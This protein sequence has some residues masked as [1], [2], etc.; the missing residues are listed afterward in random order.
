MKNLKLSHDEI[1]TLC[2]ELALFLHAGADGGSGLVLLA[3]ETRDPARK[4]LL[5]EMSRKMDEGLP[6]SQAIEASGAFPHNVAAMVQVGERTGRTEES[7]R[8]LAQYHD[9]RSQ[10]DRHLRS[11]LLYPSILLLVMLA[12][13]VVLLTRVLPIFN[14]VYA[15]L[16]GQLTGLAGGLFRL[17]ELLNTVLP[18]LCVILALAVIFLVA[19]S[20]SQSFRNRLMAWWQRRRG[21][22]G[23]TWKQ[24]CA[25]FA[26]AL[27]MG[28]SS[29]LT[30]EDA[31]ASAGV[32]LEDHPAAANRVRD[33]LTAMANGTSFTRALKEAELLPAAECRLLELG[34]ASGSSETA[35]EE[36]ARRLNLEA[37]AALEQQVGRVEPTMVVVTT[38]LVGAILLSVMLPL[39]HIMTVIG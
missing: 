15:S 22:K 7:L 10:M 18:L 38:V 8:A 16:G 4:A 17:G 13:I 19:F 1:S 3:E 34:M 26:Q 5:T 31:V 36:V 6:L 30:A 23:V 14:S 21:V 12:V 11:V 33:C 39:A 20:A 32:L 29:G 35:M 37:E 2:L 9:R 27:S 24:T 28:L 25:R